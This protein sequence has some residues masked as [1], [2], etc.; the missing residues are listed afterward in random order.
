M[1][2]GHTDADYTQLDNNHRAMHYKLN[3]EMLARFGE[4]N[5]SLMVLTQR[6]RSI[7]SVFENMVQHAS[8]LVLKNKRKEH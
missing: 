4:V 6:V 8:E 5:A 3:E 2:N 1:S 7:E